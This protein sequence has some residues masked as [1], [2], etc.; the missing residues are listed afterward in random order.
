MEH[1]GHP[2]DVAAFP[3]DGEVWLGYQTF[4]GAFGG[5]VARP[6]GL[7]GEQ[8]AAVAHVRIKVSGD[9]AGRRDMAAVLSEYMRHGVA[10]C[11]SSRSALT[12]EC[13]GHPGPLGGMLDGPGQPVENVV[14]PLPNTAGEDFFDVAPH[15]RPAAWFRFDAPSAP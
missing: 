15:Q 11:A 4:Q 10:K 6:E 12:A 14:D 2:H 3:L 7:V 9:V 5:M 8:E 13:Q 1:V